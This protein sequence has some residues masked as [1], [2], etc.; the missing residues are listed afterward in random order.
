[1]EQKPKTAP[2]PCF[3]MEYVASDP[4]CQKCPH[5]ADCVLYMGSRANKVTLD[6]V[7]FQIVPDEWKTYQYD[8]EDPELPQLQRIYVDCF[9]TIFKRSPTE[10]VSRF[11]EEIKT[12]A[13][14]AHCS[15][16]MF[17]LANMVAHE[18]QEKEV[19]N[20][21]EKARAAAFK[22]KLLTGELS[23]KRA[24][25]YKQM[26]KEKYG[27]FTLNSLNVLTDED[28]DPLSDK[29]FH[30]ELTAAHWLIRY[31]IHKRASKEEALKELY[32]CEEL[33]LCP[34]W[35]AIEES[36][37]TLVLKPYTQ[38][39]SGTDLEQAHRFNVLQTYRSYK[40]NMSQA[41]N[42]WFT[43]QDILRSAV[44]H[45]ITKFG[46]NPADFLHSRNPVPNSMDFWLDLAIAIR[47]NHCW[48]FL[49]NEPSFFAGRRSRSVD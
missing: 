40:R 35:L 13:M 14:H 8:A 39:H 7:R 45:V 43:R 18:V 26:C 32:V 9:M 4:V 48:K 10:N 47:H 29:M 28:R 11:K 49:N 5:V 42:A 36:Y 12:N 38:K 37:A 30:S 41:K 24:E 46:Y 31:R 19:I 6:K 16:R 21:S 25:M 23:V 20:H 22:A 3:G 44:V 2:L 15:I 17:F 33:Q 27:A 1:M 34:E